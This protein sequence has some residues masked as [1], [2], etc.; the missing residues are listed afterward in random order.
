MRL[1]SA[2]AIALLEIP[3]ESSGSSMGDHGSLRRQMSFEQA[4]DDVQTSVNSRMLRPNSAGRCQEF[5]GLLHTG[6]V[7]RTRGVAR[8]RR[9]PELQMTEGI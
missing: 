2:S 4:V 5:S 7:T 9:Q 6:S 3:V 8:S 1:P